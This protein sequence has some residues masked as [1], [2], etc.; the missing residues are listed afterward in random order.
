MQAWLIIQYAVIVVAVVVSAAYVFRSQC[1]R[2]ARALRLRTAAWLLRPQRVQWLQSLGRRLAP[3]TTV[4]QA[5][6]NG[7]SSC[8]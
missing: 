1:P 8:D 3:A 4:G 6:C 7:C 2:A 5:S